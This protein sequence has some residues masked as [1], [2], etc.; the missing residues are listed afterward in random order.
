VLTRVE[1]EDAV[2][3]ALRHYTRAD[4]LTRS[5]LL[6]MQLRG[7]NRKPAVTAQELREMLARTAETLF[8]D[9]RDQKLH[10]VLDI[11]YF[12]PVPKQEAA[13]ER[14]GLSFSTYRRYLRTGVLRLTDWLWEQG[15]DPQGP[16][17]KGP[18]VMEVRSGTSQR[19]PPETPRRLS[20]VVL[21]FLN[22]SKDAAE[23]YLVDGIVESLMTDLSRVLPG[24]FIISRSTAFTYRGRQLP[25][26]Q[27]GKE[28]NVRY[29]L[30]GSVLADSRHLRVNAQLIDA[31]AE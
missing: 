16:L 22:L 5:P 28:L 10:R 6:Q 4:L 19:D 14:L 8:A 15:Q 18:G 1:F 30:E 12:H 29:A 11:T 13:A 26:R 2:R 23:N 31:K 24:S 7:E 17:R 20:I 3:D 25:V 27:I 21:P 9:A